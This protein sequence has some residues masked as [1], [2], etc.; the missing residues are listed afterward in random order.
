MSLLERA[1]E[2]FV[3]MNK[4]TV[5][6]GY[7]GTK[8]TWAEGITIQG[9]MVMNN[10]MEAKIA[11]SLGAVGS[12][13]LTVKKN[14]LLDYHDVLKR[15]SDGKIFRLVNDSDDVKTPDGAGLNMR[16]YSAEE[17]QLS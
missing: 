2:P 7:G 16:Q 6:D 13:T 4:L 9:A 1:F 11:E 12:Y 3:V 14:V 15:A 17:Y 8:R 10:S 5:D